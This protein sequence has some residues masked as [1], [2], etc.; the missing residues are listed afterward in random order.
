VLNKKTF[1][2]GLDKLAVNYSC[3]LKEG[4]ASFL[5]K[6]LCD[7]GFNDKDFVVT[8][9]SIIYE[10]SNL[11]NK[12]PNLGLFL[13]HRPKKDNGWGVYIPKLERPKFKKCDPKKLKVFDDFI[14]RAKQMDKKHS[15]I[16]QKQGQI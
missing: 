14:K 15:L 7:A 6:E 8:V 13:K 9:K 12:M 16:K 4:Y 11:Y 5:Y 1:L 10:E 2:Q 3:S